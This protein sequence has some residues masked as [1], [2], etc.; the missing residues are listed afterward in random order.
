MK[1]DTFEPLEIVSGLSQVFPDTQRLPLNRNGWADYL[2][3]THLGGHEQAERKQVGE[4]L[5][6]IDSVE[7]QV[8]GELQSKP[9]V[10]LVLL[11]EGIAE[12]SP[13]GIQTY[14]ISKNG[15]VFRHGR[16]FKTRYER[17]EGFLVGL[18]S[19]GVVVWRTS[20][21]QGSLEA[22]VRFSKSAMNPD[23]SILNRYV[24]IPHF[25]PDPHVQS[26]MGIKGGDIG[27]KL[28]EALIEKFST[29]WNVLNQDAETLAKYTPGI[30]KVSAQK[31]LDAAKVK[32]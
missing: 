29:M 22:L 2:W 5:S 8:R 32:I 19:Q 3:D 15:Q 23:H 16:F 21:W 28:G 7:E 13:G 14:S 26:L 24:K 25:H 4:I 1:C 9:D 17:Y 10:K 6:N 30:G 12:P 31:L 11:V 20:S 18:E 27:P